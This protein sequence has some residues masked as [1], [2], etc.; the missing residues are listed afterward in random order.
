MPDYSLNLLDDCGHIV[1]AVKQPCEDDRD[2]L[3][4]AL[5]HVDGRDI[6]ILTFARKVGRVKKADAP[7]GAGDPGSP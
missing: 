7:V 4:R 6:E 5:S 1:D 3:N 2:A